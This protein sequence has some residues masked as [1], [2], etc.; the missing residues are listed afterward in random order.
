MKKVGKRE[1]RVAVTL[2]SPTP[3]AQGP[4]P[5]Q[6]LTNCFT[7]KEISIFLLHLFFFFLILEQRDKEVCNAFHTVEFPIRNT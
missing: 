2:L 6:C 3:G 1:A 5:R 7:I 4:K